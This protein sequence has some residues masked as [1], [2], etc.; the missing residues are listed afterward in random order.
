M[1]RRL[2]IVP[3]LFT[4][5]LLFADG[6][7]KFKSNTL[8]EGG[9]GF[10]PGR[11]YL[12]GGMG[13]INLNYLIANKIRNSIENKWSEI[14]IDGSPIWFAK[15]EYAIAPH[16][17]AGV[18]FAYGGFRVNAGLKDSITSLNIPVSGE[19]SYRTWSLLARYNFHVFPEQRFDLYGG[20]G[21]GLRSN[22][23]KVKDNDPDKDWWDFPV[24][25][26]FLSKV[27]PQSL[28]I[29]TFGLDMTL[30]FRYYIAPPVAVYA[31][32]GLAKSMAQGGITFKF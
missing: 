17:G 2:L 22:T 8:E 1:I 30:G 31:E 29:P 6:G 15:A 26:S 19:L 23:F 14:A 16:H 25:I 32:L 10:E 9:G 4:A 11:F 24:D 21:L 18:S 20:V 28:T 7:Y 3:F 27:I 12:S 5:A 13:A